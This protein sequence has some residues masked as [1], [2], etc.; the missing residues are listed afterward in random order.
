MVRA[1]SALGM[2]R[3]TASTIFRRRSLEYAFIR[4]CCH[5]AHPHR[6]TLYSSAP[7]LEYVAGCGGRGKILSTEVRCRSASE[8][9]LGGVAP[10]GC[11]ASVYHLHPSVI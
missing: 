10:S 1:A 11:Q 5:A 7:L 8:V 6:N 2:P 9:G 4:P 3:S